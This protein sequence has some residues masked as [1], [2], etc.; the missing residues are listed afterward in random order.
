MYSDSVL[1]CVPFQDTFDKDGRKEFG[2]QDRDIQQ[3]DADLNATRN[4]L[5]QVQDE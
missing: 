3:L 5:N 2:A 1:I 4:Q